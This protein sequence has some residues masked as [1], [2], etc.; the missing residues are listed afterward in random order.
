MFATPAV[1]PTT[2]VSL[3]GSSTPSTGLFGAAASSAA[4]TLNFGA[5]AVSLTTATVSSAS[6]GLTFGAATVTSSGEFHLYEVVLSYIWWGLVLAAP[7]FGLGT[8]QS[9]PSLAVAPASTSA[10]PSFGFG[11]GGGLTVP[12]LGAAVTTANSSLTFGMCHF[13][14]CN[15]G[16]KKH[17]Q[18]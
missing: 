8:T 12:S 9:A 15:C 13:R 4:P 5:P 2:T 3:F 14:A 17:F 18:V 11:L 10:A 16:K 7:T 6:G 1:T